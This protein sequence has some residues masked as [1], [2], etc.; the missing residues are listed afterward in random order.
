MALHIN[1]NITTLSNLRH[2]YDT[3]TALNKETLISH[4]HFLIP[5]FPPLSSFLSP[6]L[7][8][9]FLFFFLHLNNHHHRHSPHPLPHLH[10][11]HYFL[12]PFRCTTPPST[13]ATIHLHHLPLPDIWNRTI[14]SRITSWR[15]NVIADST[16]VS[17]Q[18][19]HALFLKGAF[20]VGHRLRFPMRVWRMF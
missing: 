13:I 16:N 10:H 7:P 8:F 18:T 15:T 20:L 6:P 3:T 5:F 9:S 4:T 17:L 1:K 11:P 2:S 12:P 14:Y 19:A